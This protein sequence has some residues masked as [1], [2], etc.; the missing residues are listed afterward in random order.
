MVG[1][2]KD[3]RGASA[4]EFAL[5]AP[6]LLLLVGAIVRLRRGPPCAAYVDREDGRC[7]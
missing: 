5:V 2:W 4:V 7:N 1:W 3:R 6:F